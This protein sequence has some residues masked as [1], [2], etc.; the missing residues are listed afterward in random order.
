MPHVPSRKDGKSD[1]EPILTSQNWAQFAVPVT[2][3]EIAEVE[4]EPVP[5]SSKLLSCVFAPLLP[6]VGCGLYTVDAKT[7]AAVLHMRCK[8]SQACTGR[9]PA[10]KKCG[11]SRPSSAPWT[12]PPPK[13][14]ILWA[15]L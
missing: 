5:L 3:E 7:E 11:T 12:F 2:G 15:T 8:T 14:P 9:S 6:F 10:A 1:S 13:L 4:I